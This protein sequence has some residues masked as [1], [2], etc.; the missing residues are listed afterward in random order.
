MG[1]D[2]NTFDLTNTGFAD[3]FRARKLGGVQCVRCRRVLKGEWEPKYC[4]GCKKPFA[5]ATKETLSNGSYALLRGD[6]VGAVVKTMLNVKALGTSLS[7]LPNRDKTYSSHLG[8]S[9]VRLD[10]T[11]EMLTDLA[12]RIATKRTDGDRGTIACSNEIAANSFVRGM[13]DDGEVLWRGF[14]VEGE[15]RPRPMVV[16]RE[17]ANVATGVNH[18][19]LKG[20]HRKRLSDGSLARSWESVVYIHEPLTWLYQDVHISLDQILGKPEDWVEVSG[21]QAIPIQVCWTDARGNFS[22][23]TIPP[24]RHDATIPFRPEEGAVYIEFRIEKPRSPYDG[25]LFY[26]V[27]A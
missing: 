22:Y 27:L 13:E 14:W 17:E 8:S 6:R 7:A 4:D 15:V 18:Y 21:G 3:A 12:A 11:E 5:K 25:S 9:R 20:Q 2:V 1:D 10:A 24:A 23:S 16:F 19:G 26:Y